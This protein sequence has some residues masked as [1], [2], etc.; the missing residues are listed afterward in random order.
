MQ[1]VPSPTTVLADVRVLPPKGLNTSIYLDLNHFA[2]E[3]AWAHGFMHAYAL[4]L[5][6]VLLAAGVVA[7]YAV[8]W[9][10]RAPRAATLLILG[11]VGTVVALGLNQ[12]VGH[13]AK[14]LRPYASHPHALVLVSRA[15]DYSFP[16]D[17]AVI[18]G[19]LTASVLLLL[20]QAARRSRSEGAPRRA[21][22]PADRR[23]IP[24]LLYALIGATV[25]LGLF[26]CFARIYVGAH[27]PGDVVAGYLL[28]AVVVA[29]L[30]LLRPLA[31]R[32]VDAIETTALASLLRRPLMAPVADDAAPG[33]PVAPAP[34]VEAPVE[35]PG[36]QSPAGGAP[37]AP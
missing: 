12:L 18:A 7:S 19:G 24:P 37:Q 35:A 11:G 31:Y 23:R 36:S 6:P 20:G 5:G 22:R 30:S 28:G 15:N 10:H 29:V 25:V 26:L 8:V 27:Y 32:L 34:P 16:S 21:G 2:R 17:H 4:W 9:W 3:T 33:Q 13:A 14:E 1:A